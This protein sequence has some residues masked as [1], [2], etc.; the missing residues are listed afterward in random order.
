MVIKTE[1]LAAFIHDLWSTWN[2]HQRDNS[3]PENVARWKQQSSTLYIALSE[4]DKDKDRKIA[5][6]IIAL[7]EVETACPCG[8]SKCFYLEHG[9]KKCCNCVRK[10]I[11]ADL[12][13][14]DVCDGKNS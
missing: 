1:R 2:V 3:T 14:C 12:K 10:E 11:Y 5:R 9:A 4:E 13:G 8:D 7:L 6:D